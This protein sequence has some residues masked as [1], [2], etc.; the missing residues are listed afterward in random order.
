MSML[1]ETDPANLPEKMQLRRDENTLM[2]V[3]SG[4][5]VFGI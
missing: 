5:I 3:G 2:V 1:N 4:V